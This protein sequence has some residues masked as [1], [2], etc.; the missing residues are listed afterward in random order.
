MNRHIQKQPVDSPCKI[1]ERTEVQKAKKPVI[2]INISDP[3][4]NTSYSF[5]V[6]V[7]VS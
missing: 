5:A 7:T 6:N 4:Q 2:V 3:E 1:S